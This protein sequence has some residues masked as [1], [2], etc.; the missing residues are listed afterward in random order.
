[1][2]FCALRWRGGSLFLKF[3]VVQTFAK[4]SKRSEFVRF[5]PPSRGV[6]F[7]VFRDFF[8]NFSE[9]SRKLSKD[10]TSTHD[11]PR[12]CVVFWRVFE[13]VSVNLSEVCEILRADTMQ[14]LQKMSK[15]GP[16][17]EVL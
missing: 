4:S 16:K 17:G 14:R 6:L 9:S 12:R 7:G 15:I 13:E 10:H 8:W 1:M 5:L 2:A 11:T 3:H